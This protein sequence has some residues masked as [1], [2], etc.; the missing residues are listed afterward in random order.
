MCL[1]NETRLRFGAK[2]PLKELP[3]RSPALKIKSGVGSS[4]FLQID[5]D[6]RSHY[7][8][9]GRGMG[10]FIFVLRDIVAANS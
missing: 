10:E 4:S 6:P 8:R 5:I 1:F 2:V 9:A 7:P 3:G